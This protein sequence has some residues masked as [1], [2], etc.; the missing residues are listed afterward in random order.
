MWFTLNLFRNKFFPSSEVSKSKTWLKI[1]G[2]LLLFYVYMFGFQII[3]LILS[4]LLG[5]SLV[6]AMLVS[7]GFLFI[8]FV[9]FVIWRRHRL[10]ESTYLKKPKVSV[11]LLTIPIGV[12]INL[13]L[14]FLLPLIMPEDLLMEMQSNF[15]DFTHAPLWLSILNLAIFA[16]LNEE[17]LCRGLIY[18]E[19]R[20]KLSIT[21][22]ILLQGVIFGIMHM[23]LVQI[24]YAVPMGILFGFIYVWT[25]S[26]W[27]TMSIHFANNLFSTIVS[28]YTEVPGNFILAGCSLITLVLL[29]MWLYRLQFANNYT[30]SK[31]NLNV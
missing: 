7:N 1:I 20:R 4:E 26:I 15:E 21:L 25:R 6:S 31:V 11:M 5:I 29:V 30:D 2:L 16:P 24:I 8:S 17:L 14:L 23:N 9:V 10:P 3:A 27:V 18:H 28:R 13:F 22:A 19:L 12:V